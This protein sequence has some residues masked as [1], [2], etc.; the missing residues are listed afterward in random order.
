MRLSF[1][2]ELRLV[3]KQVLA[4]R[5]IQSMEILQLPVMALQERI[6]QE[7]QENPVLDLV[8]EDLDLPEEPVEAENPNAP[9]EDERELV[10]DEGK[11]NEQDFER[12]MKMDEEWPD[13]FEERSRPSSTRVEEEGA[14]KHD[15]MANMVARPQSLQDYLHD[16]LGWFNLS[17]DLRAMCDRIIYNLDA[18]GYL[19]S[20]LEDIIEPTGPPEQLALA[21]QALAVVQKLD[22]PGVAARDLR[23]CL[24]LQLTPGMSHYEQL[25]TLIANHLEDLEHNRLPV[26]ERKTGYAITLI[27]ET[28][29]ELRKLNPKPGANFGDVFVPNVIPDVFV[30][31]GDDGKYRVRLEDGRMPKLF[32]SSTYRNILM[33]EKANAETREYIKRKINSAQWLIESIEQRRNTLT[34]VAQAIVDHQTEFLNKGPEFIEPL[35]MQQIAEKVGVHVTTVSRAVDDKWIQTPRGIF[36]LK[37]F[38]CGGTVSADGEEVAWDAVRL[39]LQEIIDHENKQHPLSDDELVKELAK[40]GLTV[41]RRT[42]TKYRKAMN[43]ASSRQRRDWSIAPPAGE[44]GT[45]H[46]NGPPQAYHEPSEAPAASADPTE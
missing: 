42:V 3:Q 27:Q 34:R 44:T 37:R 8:E 6:E 9:T 43:I 17:A 40:H 16:Q 5:M 39:K 1:G 21:R 19:Q 15:A 22:P 26:I 7:I 11:N 25:K 20:R 18:N 41:A 14:R 45:E 23:E 35:K 30:E 12:L 24:L 4:P 33:D 32:I 13:H 31:L 29:A 38:F 36:P 2:Q 46:H 10:V 28:L